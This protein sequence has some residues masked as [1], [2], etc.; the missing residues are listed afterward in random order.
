VT[1]GAEGG[2]VGWTGAGDRTAGA[3]LDAATIIAPAPVCQSMTGKD[4]FERNNDLF[5]YKK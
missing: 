4:G 5:L 3:T 1:P 2:R